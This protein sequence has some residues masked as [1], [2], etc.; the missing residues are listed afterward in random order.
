[1]GLQFFVFS[2]VKVNLN[3]FPTCLWHGQASA[4]NKKLQKNENFEICV[5]KENVKQS[6]FVRG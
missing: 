6:Q 1:M 2:T 3:G 4:G 5:L